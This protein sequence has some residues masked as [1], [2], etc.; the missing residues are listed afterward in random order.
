M[1]RREEKKKNSETV[2]VGGKE[3][4]REEDWLEAEHQD[5]GQLPSF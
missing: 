3:E 1:E 5:E 2:K 4:G